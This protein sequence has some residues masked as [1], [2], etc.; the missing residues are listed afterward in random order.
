M[1]WLFLRIIALLGILEQ[2]G[3]KNYILRLDIVQN[4]FELW[5]IFLS[6][7]LKPH[8]DNTPKPK[9]PQ[10]AKYAN[11]PSCILLPLAS[12]IYEGSHDEISYL[13][14]FCNIKKI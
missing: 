8:F 10:G 11:T 14:V 1:I 12:V 2:L 9:I 4:P 13:L 3:T 6:D 5:Q 7:F